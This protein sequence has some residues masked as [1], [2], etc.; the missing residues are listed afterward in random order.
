MDLPFKTFFTDKADLKKTFAKMLL[1]EYSV[2]FVL[3]DAAL[4]FLVV[5]R[6]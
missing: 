3:N 2:R 4:L 5:E 1:V 6:F